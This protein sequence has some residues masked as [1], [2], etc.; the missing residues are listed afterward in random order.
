MQN[1]T[2]QIR[3]KTQ[4]KHSFQPLTAI[5]MGAGSATKEAEI[6]Q[7]L[8]LFYPG[9]GIVLVAPATWRTSGNHLLP[10]ISKRTREQLSYFTVVRSENR[11]FLSDVQLGLE[12][13]RSQFFVTLKADEHPVEQ[14]FHFY[15]RLQKGTHFVSGCEYPVSKV[16]KGAKK[17]ISL[18][19][20]RFLNQKGYDVL[21][22]FTTL[23]AGTTTDAQKI[24]SSMST[25]ER[26]SEA[27]FFN[28]ISN[29]P[30]GTL[31]EEVFYQNKKLKM[32]SDAKAIDIFYALLKNFSRQ[33]VNSKFLKK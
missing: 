18:F 16:S 20:N 1:Q 17:I 19:A 8:S 30:S 4:K 15:Y 22:P 9:I 23:F 14:L 7:S 21:N 11:G 6:I 3:L 28:L 13:T 32:S 27:V 10:F 31:L 12:H 29:A 25:S 5:V 2:Q 26:G 24:L 33:V